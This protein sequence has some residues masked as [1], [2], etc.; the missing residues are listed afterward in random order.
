MATPPGAEISAELTASLE[1]ALAELGPGYTPRTEHVENGKPHFTNRLVR[2]TSPY[3]LQHAHNPVNWFPWSE[4]AFAEAKRLG[5]P[6]LL[7]VGYATCH[8]CHVMERESFEDLEIARYLNTH[9]VCI[10]VDREERPDVDAIYMSAVQQLHGSGGWPMTVWLTPEQ[11]PFYAGTYF[12]ARDGDRGP[13]KGFL[14]LVAELEKIYLQQPARIGEA[15]ESLTQAVRAHLA[16]DERGRG[17]APDAR[18]I[19]SAVEYFRRSFDPVHGGTM[20][21]PK[22]P[23]NIP[24]RLL[25]RH[26]LRTADA[27]ALHVATFTLERMAA[28]GM[29][30]QLGGGFHRYSVDRQWLV[31]HF[32]KMLYDNAL[33]TVAYCEAHQVTGRA[34][35][36]RVATE[37]L[38]YL[39]AE[40]RAPEG[41]FYSATDADSEGEEGRF[42][43]WSEAEIRKLL[44][45]DADAFIAHYGV[46]PSGNFEGENI[47]C[48][49]DP[50]EE[51]WA[52]L[53]AARKTL[54]AARARREP[55]LRDEKILAAWNGLAISA[56]AVGGRVLQQRRFVEAAVQAATFVLE[57]MRVGGR[58]MRSFKSGRAQHNGYLD[59]HAFLIA[60]LIDLHEATFDP[61]W[62]REAL[63]LASEVETH[64]A[65]PGGGWFMTRADHETLLARQRPS[66]DGAEPSGSSVQ[67]LN[68]LRLAELRSD[69]TLR[70]IAEQALSAFASQLAE[71]P[72]GL[73]EMLLALDWVRSSPKEVVLVW[74]TGDAPPPELA[75]VIAKTF[76]PHRVLTGA[77][78]DRIAELSQ[79]VPLAEGKALQDGKATAYVCE[80]GTCRLPVTDAEAFRRELLHR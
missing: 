75:Q 16:G 64:F 47:L 26:N 78:A 4:E 53:A 51:R 11:K 22:F 12:P 54:Y 52:S 39:L 21:A 5:R 17:G 43:V 10:K 28:G 37:T 18:V 3:L 38:D 46:S 71:Q 34:D 23:S 61:R 69:A 70:Q 62:L 68:L 19:D 80:A 50:S 24:F 7:S 42:F 13:Q 35:F 33:L 72:I 32:E 74:P 58:L 14:T 48:V 57:E 15:A 30:D 29:Y 45:A 49:P 77:R 31:P 9:Y 6:V 67:T 27:P 73:T 2:E 25:L 1:R 60:G 66:Y 36:A 65:A 56:F 63:A 55:P 8:W 40:M 59:D 76:A 44:G 20:R 41:G 79:L